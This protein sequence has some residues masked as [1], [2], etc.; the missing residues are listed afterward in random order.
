M[1][2]SIKQIMGILHEA[3]EKYI[4]QSRYIFTYLSTVIYPVIVLVILWVFGNRYLWQLQAQLERQQ[5]VQFFLSRNYQNDAGY[6][7]R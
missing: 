6:V 5:M 2:K 7:I 4:S 1:H 3:I